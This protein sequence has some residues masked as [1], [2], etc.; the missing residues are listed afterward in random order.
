[1]GLSENEMKKR[2]VTHRIPVTY[3]ISNVNFYNNNNNK[4][5]VKRELLT[6]LPD[7]Q[8]L[9]ST[10]FSATESNQN[11]KSEFDVISKT[12]WEWFFHGKFQDVLKNT[13][14][15]YHHPKFWVFFE[16]LDPKFGRL[17][18]TPRKGLYH[19]ILKALHFCHHQYTS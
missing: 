2:T 8:L 6:P 11:C 16:C 15:Q 17:A 1:M 5:Q 13:Q 19:K 14:N 4:I 12:Q 18:N 10:L 7:A 3:D 9:P